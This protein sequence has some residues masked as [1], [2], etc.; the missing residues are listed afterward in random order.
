MRR[1]VGLL[2]AGG[3]AFL[4]ALALILPEYLM[5][6][7]IVFPLDEDETITLTAT[8]ASYLSPVSLTVISGASLRATLTIKG[9]PSA[10]D[11]STAVWHVVTASYDTA[12]NQPVQP[13]TQVLALNRKSAALVQCCGA[14]VNGQPVVESGIAGYAFPVGTR[15]QT[16]QVFDP[17][18]DKPVPAS[19]LGP[20]TVDGVAAYVFESVVAPTDVGRTPLSGADPEYYAAHV[21]YWVDPRTGMLL[22]LTR[23]EHRYLVRPGSG[24]LAATLLDAD[25]VTTRASVRNLVSLDQ[26]VRDR[27]K[28]FRLLP[29]LTA[30][31]AGLAA[32]VAGIVL[33]LRFSATPAADPPVPAET[34]PARQE[35]DG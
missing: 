17:T 14:S 30:G 22:R 3:G 34:D 25:L 4:V 10:G 27:I 15:R 5:S 21:T 16:Y 2:L 20:A 23:Q 29:P 7:F 9:D 19:Y 8:G 26:R 13:M 18:L 24:A 6:Q 35:Q 31:P 12:R 11:S 1:T 28:W 32:L 33:A